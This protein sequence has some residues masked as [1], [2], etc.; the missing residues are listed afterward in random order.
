MSALL[1]PELAREMSRSNRRVAETLEA[2]SLQLEAL[3][4]KPEDV[5]VLKRRASQSA[6]GATCTTLH[7]RA[8]IVGLWQLALE[9]FDVGLSDEQ[10][11]ELLQAILNTIDNWLRVV[12]DC[13]ELWRQVTEVGCSPENLEGL[14]A[15]EMEVRRVRAEVEEMHAFITRARPPIAPGLLEMGRQESEAWETFFRLGDALA[16]SDTS[17]SETLTAAVLTMRR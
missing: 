1:L 16:A 8:N 2:E 12:Q 11:Q 6:R 14:D 15:A 13:R 10:S 5:E 4:R 3:R 17:A 7:R 9:H